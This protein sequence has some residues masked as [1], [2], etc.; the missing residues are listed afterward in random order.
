MRN[1]FFMFVLIINLTVLMSCTT[2][3]RKGDGQTVGRSELSQTEEQAK[4]AKLDDL[5]GLLLPY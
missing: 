3:S 5:R 1:I 2:A 4:Q